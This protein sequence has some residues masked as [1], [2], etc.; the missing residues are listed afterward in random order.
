MVVLRSPQCHTQTDVHETPRSNQPEEHGSLYPK[1]SKHKCQK[2]KCRTASMRQEG[3]TLV[4]TDL[5]PQAVQL[6]SPCGL[7]L[8]RGHTLLCGGLGAG[9]TQSLMTD[10]WRPLL[11][12]PAQHPC[13]VW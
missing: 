3:W 7:P 4:A 10:F 11:Y 2:A 1:A 8:Y 5:W 12:L 9:T 6:F 13:P